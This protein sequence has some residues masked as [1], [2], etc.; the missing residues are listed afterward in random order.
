ML[1]SGKGCG[2]SPEPSCSVRGDTTVSQAVAIA[3][4]S[5]RD[6]FCLLPSHSAGGFANSGGL[7]A[8]R[9][10]LGWSS[11]ISLEEGLLKV[12]PNFKSVLW[13][14]PRTLKPSI[15]EAAP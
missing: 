2:E 12:R 1:S 7:A 11:S 6:D 13:E 14:T 5:G 8:A 4:G 15:A 10:K 3:G 9:E